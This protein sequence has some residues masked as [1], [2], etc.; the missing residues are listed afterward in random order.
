MLY[1]LKR[2][3][4][5][6]FHPGVKSLVDINTSRRTDHTITIRSSN[7]Y[8]LVFRTDNNIFALQASY[9]NPQLENIF[10][11][12]VE[13]LDNTLKNK[14]SMSAFEEIETKSLLRTNFADFI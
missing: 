4:L 12:V 2:M 6:G 8:Y 13:K 7:L 9:H 11:Q 3:Q 10:N 1:S 14:D 5:R